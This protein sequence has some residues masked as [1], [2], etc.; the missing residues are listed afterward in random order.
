MYR[1]FNTKL[2]DQIECVESGFQFE[3]EMLIKAS[4]KG[5]KV[6]HIAIPTIYGDQGSTIKNIKDSVKFI[7]LWFK[8]FIWT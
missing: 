5:W 6:E 1:S 7:N 3:S 4:L 8:S 2:F